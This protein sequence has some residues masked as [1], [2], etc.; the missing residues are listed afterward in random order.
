MSAI[1]TPPRNHLPRS[2]T[3]LR[4]PSRKL[5]FS[6]TLANKTVP[7]QPRKLLCKPPQ[8]QGKYAREDYLVK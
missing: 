2:L 8:A 6:S 5:I 7:W 4:K 3:S 1:Q